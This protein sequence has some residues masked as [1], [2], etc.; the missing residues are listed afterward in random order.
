MRGA[1]KTHLGRA[2]AAA[3]G[4]TFIDL[5]EAYEKQHG[6]IMETV[7]SEGWPVFRQREVALLQST[8]TESPT[9][10]VIAC[11]GGIVET[12]EGRE[13][14]KAH[15]PVVQACKP[16]DE[17]EAY[18]GFDSTRPDLGEP[19]RSAYARRKKWYDEC[20]DH[21][22]LAAPKEADFKASE[23][24]LVSM[25]RRVLRLEPPAPMPHD[26]S[27][28]ISL[29]YPDFAAALPLPAA[30]WTNT[31]AVE[32][33]CDLLHS[34][35]PSAVQ[36]QIA[37][38]RANCPLPIIFTIR[39]KDEGGKFTGTTEEYLAL[40]E[41]ALR[42]GCPWI[43][44]EAAR[45]GKELR[46]F[47]QRCRKLNI[48]LIGSN[49]V[50]GPMPA[51]KTIASGL[52]R[53]E[54]QGNADVAKFVGVAS[55]PSH[56]LH[57]HAAASSANLS[58]PHIALAMGP[59]GQMS[60]VLNSVY[61]PVTHPLLPSVAAPGQMSAAQILDARR[62]YGYLPSRKFCIFGNPTKYSPSPAMHNAAFSANG[63]AHVYG[64]CE[65]DDVNVVLEELAKPGAGGG[66]VT[67]PLKEQLMTHVPNLS[68]SAKAIGSL[69]TL[70]VQSD[71]SLYADNTDW[72]GIHNLL[73]DNLNDRDAKA[74]TSTPKDALV[75]I[76]MGGGGTARAAC[77]A[78]QQLKVGT[79]Y[80]Y[81]RSAD[82]AAALAEEFGGKHMNEELHEGSRKLDR[83]DLVVSCV[84]G[85]AGLTLPDDVLKARSPIV[86]DAAY[87]PRE[88]PL[89][90]AAA[91]AGCV[92]I[93]GIE[94]LFEQGCAQAEIWTHRPAP[95]AAIVAGLQVFTNSQEFGPLPA[96][97][98]AELA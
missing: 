15:W 42:A 64:V 61:T 1:G 60:R 97:L 85:S 62:A 32:L 92:T 77:Y 76:V 37:I 52:K 87:R 73:R 24:R 50:L 86:L 83:I 94:M 21:D 89:L 30:L 81:N 27:F 55:E 98:T 43:D 90:A 48:R 39:S 57:V 7:K 36:T 16:I 72:I 68:P 82:K 6:K 17:I 80:V 9:G 93:E 65:T 79:F 41:L 88:T 2:C 38:L 18:L 74:K 47:A 4:A 28:F 53:C 84:P 3:L 95:R 45:D 56:A 23:V 70:T 58:M 19:P 8:L 26:H 12:E 31:D 29:T 44:L 91:S 67:I 34:L 20:A 40:N 69:N 59:A 22:H 96:R 66:S 78:L 63:C 5:D 75:G 25:L 13:R 10:C 71:G 46:A 54:L 11:G 49:H 51:A 33:R 14:L 35:E